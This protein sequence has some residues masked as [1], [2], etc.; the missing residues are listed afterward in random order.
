VNTFLHSFG[1]IIMINK[2]KFNNL[3]PPTL[4]VLVTV[5]LVIACGKGELRDIDD[6]E[7]KREIEKADSSLVKKIS[8]FSMGGGS[9]SSKYTVKCTVVIDTGSVD[10][11]IPSGNRPKVECVETANPANVL[12]V[13]DSREDVQWFDAPVWAFPEVGDYP[14][15]KVEVYK[16]IGAC[17]GL[18]ATCSGTFR[19]CPQTGCPSSSSMASSSSVIIDI[20]SSGTDIGTSSSSV[21]VSSSSVASSSSAKVTILCQLPET[22]TAGATISVETQR[23]YLKCS[24]TE[25]SPDTGIP[26]WVVIEAPIATII[27]DNK[28]TTE[29]GEYPE[30]VVFASCGAGV[31]SS[32]NGNCNKVSIVAPASSSS[33]TTGTSSATTVTSSSSVATVVSSSSRA[34]SSSVQ[35]AVQAEQAVLVQ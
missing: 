10:T 16:G 19:V 22:L 33:A 5:I 4:A 11:A 2:I 17:E 1:V 29:L 8:S 26:M 24:N 27:D 31:L 35:Q 15:I 13:L 14:S 28:V 32:I 20:G 21:G 12:K 25:K 18:T 6:D 3:I 30:I 23:S 34:S 9:A 7:L